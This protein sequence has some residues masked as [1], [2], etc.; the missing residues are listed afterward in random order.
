MQVSVPIA[1]FDTAN[2][3]KRVRH[4]LEM[5]A[6]EPVSNEQVAEAIGLTPQRLERCLQVRCCQSAASSPCA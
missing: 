6:D 5:V 1:V 3:I 2:K 4:E